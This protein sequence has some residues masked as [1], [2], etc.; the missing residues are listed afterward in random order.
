MRFLGGIKSKE[1]EM[2]FKG[3]APKIDEK[4]TIA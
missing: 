4:V 2:A 1:K 3:A